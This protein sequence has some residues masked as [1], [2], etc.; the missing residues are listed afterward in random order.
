MKTLAGRSQ[1]TVAQWLTRPP[2]RFAQAFTVNFQ[3][4]GQGPLYVG[5][6]MLFELVL[7]ASAACAGADIPSAAT[8][9]T[10]TAPVTPYL[11]L[12]LVPRIESAS[13]DRLP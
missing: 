9:A 1:D 12:D 11:A 3:L 13:R 10:V 7:H 6:S 2:E 4:S 8:A 5:V